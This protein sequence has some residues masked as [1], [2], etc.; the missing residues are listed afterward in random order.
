V[1]LYMVIAALGFAAVENILY[2]FSP[3][4]QMSLDETVNRALGIAI[5]RFVGATFL[6]TLC[7][8]II[9]YSIAISF[10]KPKRK[11]ATIILGILIAVFLHG[12]YNFSLMTTEGFI[13]VIIP[14]AIIFT[15]AIL[16]L[17]GFSKLKKMKGECE[18]N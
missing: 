8:A 1:M 2:L 5:I 3:A 13:Q 4:G 18:I 12:L 7:S 11:Y 15:L 6:H 16:V 14:I 17:L 9:G 10:D